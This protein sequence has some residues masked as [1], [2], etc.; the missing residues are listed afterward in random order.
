ME[1][2]ASYSEKVIGAFVSDTGDEDAVHVLLAHK[3]AGTRDQARRS[4]EEN[5]KYQSFVESI[6][7]LV[8]HR[9]ATL[10]KPVPYSPLR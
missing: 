2:F 9:D 3:S 4:L 5:D 7:P 8:A 6:A 1:I 10:L